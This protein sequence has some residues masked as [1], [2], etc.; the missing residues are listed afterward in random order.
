MR[1][2]LIALWAGILALLL[3]ALAPMVPTTLAQQSAVNNPIPV[4]GDNDDA[5]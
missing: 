5:L 4:T 1:L 3:I 2:R